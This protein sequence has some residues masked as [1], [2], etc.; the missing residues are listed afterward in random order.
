MQKLFLVTA[1]AVA[2][3]SLA[4]CGGDIATAAP[5]TSEPPAGPTTA[6]P[7]STVEPAAVIMIDPDGD[8][9]NR[10]RT[11]REARQLAESVREAGTQL[12]ANFCEQGYI[13]G[14]EG[15]GQFPSG[16]QAWLDACEEGVRQAG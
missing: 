1:V 16:R 2:A 4:A 7:S 15:G 13:E 12:P 9:W 11:I 5:A 3:V 8:K 14:L 10:A 6:A